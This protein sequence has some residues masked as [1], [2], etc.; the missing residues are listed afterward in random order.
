MTRTFASQLPTARKHVH[1]NERTGKVEMTEP[2][3]DRLAQTWNRL[4]EI[5]RKTWDKADID[6]KSQSV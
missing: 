2:E 6:I 3:W 5:E 1:W 4:V